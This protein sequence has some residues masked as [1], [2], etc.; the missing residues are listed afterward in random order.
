MIPQ[1]IAGVLITPSTEVR[2]LGVMVDSDLSLASHITKT[3]SACYY[4]LRQLRTI[5]RSLSTDVAH[6][7]ARAL[8]HSRLDYC[9]GVLAGMPQYRINRLQSVLRATARFVLQLPSRESVTELMRD[10][11]HWLPFPARVTFKLCVT[12]YKCQHGLAPSYLSELCN[13][14]SLVPGRACLRSAAAGDLFVPRTR[15]KTIGPRGFS[16]AGP[17]SWNY[18]PEYLKNNRLTFNLFKQ[19]L[20]TFLFT[21]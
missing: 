6:S 7:M 5:R 12:A 3:T 11:L 9:N 17:S 8:I 10:Q 19:Q 2:D 14:V 4:H 15:T 1:D 18:L 20:K 16:F 13:P 21:Q